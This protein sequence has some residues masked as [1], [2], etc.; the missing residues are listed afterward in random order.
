MS[1]TIQADP[2]FMKKA[3]RAVPVWSKLS[4]FEGYAYVED[5]H[6]WIEG[7]GISGWYRRSILER[8]FLLNVTFERPTSE[9]KDPR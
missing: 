1:N 8:D 2:E 4:G 3:G 6:V 5:P 9:R 7:P